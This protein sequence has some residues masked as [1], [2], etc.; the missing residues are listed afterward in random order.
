MLRRRETPRGVPRAVCGVRHGLGC[1]G[2]LG[3]PLGGPSRLSFVLFK[4]LADLLEG[5]THHG[6]ARRSLRGLDTASGAYQQAEVRPSGGG[7]A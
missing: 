4:A 7:V 3:G 2:P 6:D 5:R 1:L